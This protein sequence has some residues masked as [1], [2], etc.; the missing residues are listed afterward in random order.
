MAKSI[1]KN[2]TEEV[3]AQKDRLLRPKQANKELQDSEQIYRALFE[4]A[5]FAISLR[6]PETKEMIYNKTE[7][8]SLGYTQEEYEMMSNPELVLDSPAEME[9]RRQLIKEKGSL[10]FE[11][12]L[13]A[14]DGGIRYRLMSSVAVPIKGEFYDLNI[15]SD[16]TQIKK[17]E[18]SLKRAQN[19]LEARVQQRTA[20]L[21]ERTH[22]LI[23]SNTALKV[24]LEK[25]DEVILD[26]EE[27]LLENT[28]QRVLPH[29]EKLKQSQ[30]SE[31]QMLS[32]AELESSLKDILSPFLKR[33]TN[34]YHGLTPSQIRVA[35]Y[36]RE[37]K[38]SKEIAALLNVAPKTIAVHRERIRKKLGLT[39]SKVNLQAHLRSLDTTYKA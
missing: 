29:V 28:R 27:R 6:N 4:H 25:R 38:S 34:E 30:L 16:I 3:Q 32:L 39:H 18:N 2:Q 36:I 37:G 23:E 1:D 20:E 31:A 35:T 26:V 15:C 19:E 14:K 7:Y 8:E 5:G 9:M 11:S 33:L 10:V 21:N 13:R 17:T 24:L 12:K 22:D